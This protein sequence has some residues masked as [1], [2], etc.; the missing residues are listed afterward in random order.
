MIVEKKQPNIKELISELPF[1]SL[2]L[3][4]ELDSGPKIGL[5]GQKFEKSPARYRQQSQKSCPIEYVKIDW[6]KFKIAV[7]LLEVKPI[8]F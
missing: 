1:S 4:T 5:V 6:S 2:G 3:E 7:L 8:H